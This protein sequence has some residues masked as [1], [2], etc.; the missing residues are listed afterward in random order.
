MTVHHNHVCI[1]YRW[2][3][4]LQ[5]GEDKLERGL[6]ARPA[7]CVIVFCKVHTQFHFCDVLYIPFNRSVFLHINL[8]VDFSFF[9]QF[10]LYRLKCKGRDQVYVLCLIIHKCFL[11]SVFIMFF[12]FY[13]SSW[14]IDEV[15]LK[16]PLV[17]GYECIY[18][19]FLVLK[20]PCGDINFNLN[21]KLWPVFCKC[22]WSS[23][24]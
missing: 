5:S 10:F 13:Q 8:K 16:P 6:A 3:G 15:D 19:S 9:T 11:F 17:L 2:W 14:N 20:V 1:L 22:I 21:K 4:R 7:N 24:K 18:F 23:P 12:V